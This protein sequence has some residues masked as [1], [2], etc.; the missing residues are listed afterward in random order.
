MSE[1]HDE[2]RV[3]WAS[4]GAVPE[5]NTERILRGIERQ[6][7]EFRRRIIFRDWREIVAGTCLFAI[8]IWFAV[9]A[10]D[11]YVRAANLWIAANGLWIGFCMWR[12]SAVSRDVKRD[13]S[14][15]AYRQALLHVYSSQIALLKSAIFW[16]LLPMWASLVALALAQWHAGHNTIACLVSMAVQ[17]VIFGFIW[18]LNESPGVRCLQRRQ[19]ELAG[20]IQGL[21]GT[22]E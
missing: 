4:D 12:Y 11:L 6:A 16:Y 10:Q 15:A 3:I 21:E 17:T 18:W 9:R 22:M 8:F 1:S 20:L 7:S 14:V 19:A 2:L 5:V 13:Q